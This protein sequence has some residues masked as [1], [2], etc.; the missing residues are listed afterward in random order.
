CST[1]LSLL[2]G[3]GLFFLRCGRDRRRGSPAQ[4]LV[5]GLTVHAR[6][7]LRAYRAAG[8]HRRALLRRNG[9]HS[10]TRRTD[11]R[12]VDGH[13]DAFI[14]KRGD[15]RLS[16]TKLRDNLGDIKLRICYEC[17]S[18]GANGLLVARSIRPQRMLY[19]ISKLPQN[20][21]RYIIRNLRAKIHADA[22]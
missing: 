14:S 11:L 5:G 17:F 22:F 15:E 16:Y 10:T 3:G 20:L 21:V 2:L 4:D 13:L 7:I 19:S 6:V 1:R 8:P 12:V 9:S 18:G